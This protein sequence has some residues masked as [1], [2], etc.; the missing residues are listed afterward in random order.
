MRYGSCVDHAHVVKAR[1][2]QAEPVTPTR[3]IGERV[4]ALRRHRGWTQ[5]DLA[6]ALQAVGIDVER[7]VIAKLESGRRS[8]VK[9]D[10][11][12][13]LCVV[14]EISPTDMLVPRDLQDERYYR[15]VPNGTAQ[16]ANTRRWIA[17]ED[18]LFVFHDLPPDAIFAAPGTIS[19]PT[20][21]MPAERAER[22]AERYDDHLEET[23]Q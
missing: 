3:V 17:G 10:E 14:L 23:D 7:I 13:A 1:V 18:L 20:E 4:A 9:V 15:V 5:Q 11:L 22:V 6:E 21:W 12:L 19:D 16:V 8:F 2:Q